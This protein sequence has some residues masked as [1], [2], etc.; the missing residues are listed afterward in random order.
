MKKTQP[1]KR[2]MIE[3]IEIVVDEAKAGVK[4]VINRSGIESLGENLKETL[5]DA[6]SGR[7]NVVMV[8][9]NRESLSKIDDLVEA[10][11]V[12]SRSESSAYL[13][14][15]GIRARTDLFDRIS[16]KINQIRKAKLELKHLLD[17]PPGTTQ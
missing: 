4:E 5:Q 6:L 15:E 12:N 10:G 2:R 11:V 7:K 1:R 16:S 3:G 8:R 17:D 9:L 13:I 14:E